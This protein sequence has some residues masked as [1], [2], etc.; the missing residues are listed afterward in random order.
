MQ[1]KEILTGKK[2]TGRK[3]RPMGLRT[4]FALGATNGGG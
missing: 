4:T 1:D 3:G 2:L